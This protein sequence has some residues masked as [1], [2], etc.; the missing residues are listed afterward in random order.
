MNKNQKLSKKTLYILLAISIIIIITLG[1]I[2]INKGKN[3]ENQTTSKSTSLVEASRQNT[4]TNTEYKK[5]VGGEVI[6]ETTSFSEFAFISNNSIYIFNP[7][8][9]ETEELS[10]KK[11][12]DIPST[13]Q[14]T[15]ISPGYGPDIKFL[16]NNDTLYTLADENLDN[17]AT[18]NYD[19][20]EKAIYKLSDYLKWEYTT[21]YLGKKI[22]YDIMSNYVYAKDNIL[23]KKEYNNTDKYP[24]IE[25]I[26]GNY[27]GQKII[28]IYNERIVK[29]D[30]AFYEIMSYFDTNQNKTIT[31]T[32]K[33]NMLTKYYDEVLNFT[34]KY[35]ILKD[36]T[37][38]PI[39]DTM[40]KRV[41]K[42]QENYFLSG[43]NSM[44]E[45]QY[46][47]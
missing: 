24:T 6:D 28:K 44:D 46:E 31:T 17:K 38:I 5:F 3:K 26:E 39:N 27:E 1:I 29:T 25:K 7:Q 19:T 30:K 40:E 23:Y 20:Y 16:D 45:V 8:K 9:L 4:K 13:I 12:Y 11:V 10:Y 36:Y 2:V 33:I 34:Y 47:E 15:T 42:Y 43:F 32:V 35:V 21:T 37:L 18:G 41:R 14:A 22:D